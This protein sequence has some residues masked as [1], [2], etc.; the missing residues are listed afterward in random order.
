MVSEKLSQIGHSHQ[1]ICISHLP[2]IVS[3]ADTHFLIEKTVE[4][5]AT[6][7]G[8]RQ[9]DE[10]DSVME[11]ARLLGGSEITDTTV[12]GAREMKHMAAVKKWSL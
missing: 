3:M 9:L 11:L 8:I 12:A 7:T 6:V 10:E 1:V 5:G 4:Q 2:Q